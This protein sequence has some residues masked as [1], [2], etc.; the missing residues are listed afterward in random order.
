MK[1]NGSFAFCAAAIVAISATA[2][3]AFGMGGLLDNGLNSDLAADISFFPGVQLTMGSLE[4]AEPIY[5]ASSLDARYSECAGCAAAAAEEAALNAPVV[6]GSGIPAAVSY[7]YA[8]YIAYARAPFRPVRAAVR[9]VANVFTRVQPVRRVLSRVK[10]LFGCNA[11][12]LRPAYVCDPC[13]SYDVCNVCEPA[14]VCD[15]CMTNWAPAAAP[16]YNVCD[17]C[18]IP[19]AIVPTSV[20]APRSCCGYGTYP[21]EVNELNPETGLPRQTSRNGIPASVDT[22]A[23]ADAPA[24]PATSVNVVSTDEEDAPAPSLSSQKVAPADVESTPTAIPSYDSDTL[25]PASGFGP[26]EDDL[27]EDVPTPQPKSNLGAGVIR[28][29]VP[30]DAVV[31]VNGYRTKQKGELRSF[32]A[33]ELEIG[34]TYA[35]EIRVVAV[36]NGRVYEDVQNTTLTADANVS[37]AFNLKL[38]ENQAYAL[39]LR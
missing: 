5:A 1:V 16:A 24:A 17:P 29:L 10:R 35:F 36:R 31:Y 38:Q 7:D 2:A 11:S 21:G 4:K 37:L 22:D 25:S 15:P 8:P 30:E 28:M 14:P 3:N 32:A 13:W 33:R 23:A 9:P 34:E 39:N 27:L 12:Y 20:Y 19:A 6:V 18:G 26:A